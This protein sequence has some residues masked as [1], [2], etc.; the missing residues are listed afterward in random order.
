VSPYQIGSSYPTLSAELDDDASIEDSFFL[1]HYG[2]D[3]WDEQN[4]STIPLNS[5]EGRLVSFDQRL[6]SIESEISSSGSLSSSLYLIK[7][8]Q[9][10][11][12]SIIPTQGTVLPL[13]VSATSANFQEWQ[14]S[15]LSPRAI[16]F[17]N[18]NG[19]MS[20]SGYASIVASTSS[21]IAQNIRVSES[22]HK[23]VVVKSA[24]L[25]NSNLQ[26]WQDSQGL[27]KSYVDSNGSIGQSKTL[28][29]ITSSTTLNNLSFRNKLIL[30]NS[31]STVTITIP[32]DS[33]FSNPIGTKIEFLRYGSGEVLFDS[34]GAASISSESNK[35]SIAER[36]SAATIIKVNNNLWNLYGGLKTL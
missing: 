3:D 9:Q 29:N 33:S 2:V 21:S 1:Y 23:G 10:G 6:S 34:Q 19:P 15:G 14:N 17:A 7:L 36:Y 11:D 4:P 27:I 35:N 5:I 31:S 16:I 18:S 12:N 13:S 20:I 8:P 25:Q 28:V 22:T 24:E 32:E 30:V 26:E